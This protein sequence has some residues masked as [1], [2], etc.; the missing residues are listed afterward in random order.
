MRS[1]PPSTAPAAGSATARLGSGW[2]TILASD[3]FRWAIAIAVTVYVC[4]ATFP[5]AFWMIQ[6]GL[7]ES[8]VW[9]INRLP[10]T[11][12]VFGRD[13]A[14]T[15]GP[16][17]Y[18]LAPAAISET[19]F[20]AA[21]FN[22]IAQL[23]LAALAIFHFA[24]N[25]R[26]LPLVGFGVLYL[27]A[28]SQ[29]LQPEFRLLIL[30]ALLL[31]VPPTRVR[32]WRVASVAAA[33]LAAVLLFA[34]FSGIAAVVMLA[35]SAATLA[36]RK[37]VSPR[38]V[39]AW[40]IAPFVL[41]IIVVGLPLFHNPGNFVRWL[42]AG[43]E[44]LQGY[45]RSM[46]LPYPPLL[47]WLG[48]LGLLILGAALVWIGRSDRDLAFAW[49]PLV[50]AAAV[51][52]RYA[53]TR[54][55]GHPFF[56]MLLAVLA[57]LILTASS[58]R[59][60][61]G[62]LVAGLVAIPLFV[63][64]SAPSPICPC[65][66]LLSPV[67]G[68]SSLRGLADLT[69]LRADARAA[70]RRALEVE[71]LPAKWVSTIKANGGDV[72]SVPADLLFLKANGLP[73]DPDPVLQTYFAYTPF[74]DRWAASHFADPD[75]PDFVIAQWINIDSRHPMLDAPAVWRSIVRGYGVEGTFDGFGGLTLLHRRPEPLPSGDVLKREQAR[76]G[77]WVEV[78]DSPRLLFASV[79]FQPSVLGRLA[80]LVWRVDPMFI[81]LQYA[82]GRLVTWRILPTTAE[83]GMLMNL[84]P[85]SHAEVEALFSGHLTARV[86][87]VRFHGPGAG[88]FKE[89]LD[90]VW[91]RGPYVPVEETL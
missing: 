52:F 8:W 70:A 69:E 35:V 2:A 82:D 61:A 5:G 34:K 72:D 4:V 87:G 47:L 21:A 29:A 73:W 91:E 83:D 37:Q 25:R 18:L 39:L 64:G 50:V 62:V 14:F 59:M 48:F 65:P 45:A 85:S 75:G 30:E 43:F 57:V 84:L 9:A 51:A 77:E 63:V 27:F 20:R 56:Q 22:V 15:Y 3:R 49:L 79:R 6:P 44:G 24:T 46:A 10:S 26:I 31:A 74:L 23:T 66:A 1:S 80:G 90:I 32:I 89:E 68:W 13:L 38:G 88:S 28:L 76:I 53:F 19:I 33:V 42:R 58:R 54:S 41:A 11:D 60:L 55:E 16:L 86:I 71:R 40:R 81:D 78:P 36:L 7:D 17:G 67:S 12:L